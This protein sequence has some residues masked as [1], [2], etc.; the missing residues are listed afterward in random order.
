MS[1][2]FVP[3]GILRERERAKEGGREALTSEQKIYSPAP[4]CPSDIEAKKVLQLG[5]RVCQVCWDQVAPISFFKKY[6]DTKK[7]ETVCPNH[8][9][10]NA[11]G[12][13]NA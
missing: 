9:L 11:I 5:K 2:A 4:Q 3:T 10:I 12:L 6:V 1:S 8:A 7:S 13:I